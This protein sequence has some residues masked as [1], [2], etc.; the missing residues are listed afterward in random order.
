LKALEANFYDFTIVGAGSSGLWLANALN[1]EG[2]LKNQTLIIVESD[3]HKENDRTWCYW[4]EKPIEPKKIISKE[5]KYLKNYLSA[6]SPYTYYHVRSRDF[7]REIKSKLKKNKNIFWLTDTMISQSKEGNQLKIIAENIEWTTKKL[8]LSALPLKQ[9]DDLWNVKTFLHQKTSKNQLFLW[10]SFAGWRIKTKT[11]FFNP[12]KMI[13]MDFNI[14]QNNQTQFLYELPFSE[15]E[16][17]LEVTRFS[18]QKISKTEAEEIISNYLKDKNVIYEIIEEEIGAIPM[19]NLFDQ[20]Q[21]TIPK[22]AQIIYIGTLGGA[23]KPTTG[24]GFKRMKNYADD[25]AIAIKNNKDLPSMYRK[26]RFRIYD[27][28]LLQIIDQYP[29][30]GK[31]IF[32]RL[33]ISQPLPRIL[34]FLDEETTCTEELLIFSKLPIRLFLNSLKQLILGR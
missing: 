5:W 16:A 19:T 3:A 28:L 29:E 11:P 31:E 1:N 14:P 6:L 23:I 7:Y 17:L 15:N 2:I 4:D 24:Y 22:S 25:L 21:K 20:Y 32:E 8:F 18:K 30:R 9:K 33:F 12:S 27:I 34:K 13:M 10:Q 26:Q